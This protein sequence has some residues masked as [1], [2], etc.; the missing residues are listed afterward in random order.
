MIEGLKKLFA[1]HGFP[2]I[3]E[4]RRA[5]APRCDYAPRLREHTTHEKPRP[6]LP[7][8]QACALARLL[9]APLSRL[10]NPPTARFARLRTALPA[11]SARGQAVE[12]VVLPS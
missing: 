9:Q 8:V 12:S 11:W 7:L 6:H 10:P 5:C 4:A 2:T 3:D 1:W